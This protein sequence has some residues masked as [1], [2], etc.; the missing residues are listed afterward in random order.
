MINVGSYN[1]MG[2]AETNSLCGKE[3]AAV[4][5]EQGLSTCCSIQQL[6]NI[7]ACLLCVVEIFAIFSL[8][9]VLILRYD[10]LSS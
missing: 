8:I 2:F 5:D 1:Y 7:H 6:G 10:Y 9:T 4:I 3:A